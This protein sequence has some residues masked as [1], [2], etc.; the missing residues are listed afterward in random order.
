M[1]ANELPLN[2]TFNSVYSR[3]S[4]ETAAVAK[5]YSFMQPL[6]EI[7]LPYVGGVNKRLH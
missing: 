1:E 6:V 7:Y 3:G 2:N 5:G 4:M